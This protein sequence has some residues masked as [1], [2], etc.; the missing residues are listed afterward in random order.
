[1]NRF[2]ALAQIAYLRL[3]GRVTRERYK[4]AEKE[5]NQ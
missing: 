3:E 5:A 2:E 1:M 4:K